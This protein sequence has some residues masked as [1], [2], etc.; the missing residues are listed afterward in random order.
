[1]VR[2]IFLN[3]LN[4]S[5]VTYVQYPAEFKPS[6]HVSYKLAQTFGFITRMKNR[7]NMQ[8]LIQQQLFNE[9]LAVPIAW[10]HIHVP[11]TMK[12]MMLQYPQNIDRFEECD[13]LDADEEESAKLDH[14]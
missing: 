13:F 6:L 2:Y 5:I 11:R 9:M 12:M 1:M 8:R 7:T 4:A 10:H 3:S 14:I